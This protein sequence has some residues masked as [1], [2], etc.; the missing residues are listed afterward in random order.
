MSSANNHRPIT[1]SNNPTLP[2][3]EQ[4]LK[5][6]R[7]GVGSLSTNKPWNLINE[8]Q[9]LAHFES[10]VEGINITKITTRN[11]NPIGNLPIELLQ[12]LNSCC[13]LTLEP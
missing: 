1:G 10:F 13:F 12:N 3:L 9:L 5:I 7:V 4:S 11:D 2:E 8:T 6:K